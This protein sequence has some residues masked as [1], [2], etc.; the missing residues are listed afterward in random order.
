MAERLLKKKIGIDAFVSSPAR[1]AKK[2]A[3][4]FAK[5]YGCKDEDIILITALY[6]APEETFYEV[7][8]A[9]DEKLDTVALFAHNPGITHFANSLTPVVQLDNMPTCS[10]FAVQ[11]DIARWADFAK[12]KKEYLFFDYPKRIE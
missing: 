9:L 4:L 7:V 5:T 1:R 11:C 6:Q 8:A 10:V 3:E 12:T 2:T